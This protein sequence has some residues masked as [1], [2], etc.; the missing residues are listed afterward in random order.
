MSEI[1]VVIPNYNGMKYLAECMTSLCREQQNAPGY[2]VL[3]IDNAS[4][5]GSVE[6]L[7]K[8][9]CGEGVRLI[10]LPENTGFCH[11]VNLGIREA[12]TPYVILLNN[13][14]KAEAGFVRGLYDA[15][16][17]NEKIFS[18]SAKMLMWDRPE[19]IDDAGDRYCVLGWAYSRG[20]G[21]PAA[22][23]DKSVPVFSACGGAAIYRRSV[24]EEIGYFD[25][26]H[27]AYLED[28]D[29]GYR[30]RIYG[31]ENWYAPKAVVYHVGSGTSGSRYN[32]FKTRYSSRNNVYLIYKNM[33]L[34]QIILNLPFLLAGFLIKFLF[35]AAKG[36]GKEYLAGIKNG[37]SIS[38]KGHKV[39]FSMK[40]LSNYAR[41]QLELWK[42][43]FLRF[44]A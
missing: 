42:N 39:P 44:T 38:R 23:Y 43:I 1:T 29:I 14:T 18:V 22:D 21:R 17:E 8:E 12:K 33:P 2:E 36:M 11:A 16:R 19:L 13:D 41:I 34:F 40:H 24:F 5:D 6:Y 3:I 10:S 27:F 31:Y 26:E 32:Q 30:A 28:T 35:F 25:E 7:Q 37:F 4:V 20:K 15:I 9:W